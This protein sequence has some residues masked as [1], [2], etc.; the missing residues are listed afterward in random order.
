MKSNERFFLAAVLMALAFAFFGCTSD[1]GDD[2]DGG[3]D[4]AEG[5]WRGEGSA[6]VEGI[7]VNMD[8]RLI[9]KPDGTA[10]IIIAATYE[11]ADIPPRT[12]EDSVFWRQEGDLVTLY[13]DVGESPA[14]VNGNTMFLDVYGSSMSANFVLTRA[15]ICSPESVV[16]SKFTDSRDG[17]EYSAV[18]ICSQTWMAENLNYAPYLADYWCYDNDPANCDIYGKLYDWNTAVAICPRGWHLPSKGE[19]DVLVNSVGELTAGTKLKSASGWKEYQGKPGNGT[20][21]YGFAALPGGGRTAGG[22]YYNGGSTGFWWTASE[23]GNG[24]IVRWYMSDGEYSTWSPV[25]EGEGQSVRC[26]KDD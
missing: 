13:D 6:I 26:V 15:I 7:V 2:D 23:S 10:T 18:K 4:S 14:T 12:A 16:R 20:D 5:M 11:G 17:K 22:G 8:M 9:L 25:S 19:W 1:G 3:S 24:G 21:E